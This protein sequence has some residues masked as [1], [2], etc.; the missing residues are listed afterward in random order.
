MSAYSVGEK[1]RCVDH[2]LELRGRRGIVQSVDDTDYMVRLDGNG[3]S[4]AVLL[5]EDQLQGD[6]TTHSIDYSQCSA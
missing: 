2:S 5:R 6:S 4:Q 3:C 1:V